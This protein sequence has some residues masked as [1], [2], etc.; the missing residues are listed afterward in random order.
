MRVQLNNAVAVGPTDVAFGETPVI[1]DDGANASVRTYRG[2]ILL[3][4]ND[5]NPERITL[6]DLSTPVPNV[7]VGDHYSGPIV[8]VM[9]SVEGHDPIRKHVRCR[10]NVR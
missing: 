9:V 8:G 5:G 2:G 10:Q 3:R 4:P 6:D 7:N 1:G